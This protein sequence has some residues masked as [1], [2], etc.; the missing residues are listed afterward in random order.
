MNLNAQYLTLC[1]QARGL[2]QIEVLGRQ[3]GVGK[4]LLEV[5]K[6]A[7]SKPYSC[8]LISLHPQTPDVLRYIRPGDPI[9]VYTPKK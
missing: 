4:F 1:R 8:L 9:F 2:D 6:D 3:L 7:T 5:F